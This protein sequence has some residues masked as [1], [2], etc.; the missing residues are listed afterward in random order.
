MATEAANR[1]SKDT[2]ALVREELVSVRDDLAGTIKHMSGGAILVGAAAGSALLALVATH[3]AILQLL[4]SVMPAS[5][6]GAVLAASYVAAATTLVLLARKQ[7][8]AA[9]DAMSERGPSAEGGET[10]EAA[11]A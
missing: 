11:A 6:A 3:E 10:D 9:A 2:S 5:A 4:E 7:L 8:K 1:L